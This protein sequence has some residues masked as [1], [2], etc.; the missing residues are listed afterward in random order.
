MKYAA[1]I[2]YRHAPLDMEIA[3]KVHTALET[4]KI[5]GSVRKKV[6]KSK[7][8]RVFRDQEELPIGSNLSDNISEAL[9]SSEYLI[10][11][12]SPRTPE[13]YWVQK[14]IDAFISM[15]GRDRVLAVLI[16]GEPDESFPPALLVDEKG[17]PVEPLAAD[18]RG[19]TKKERN[20]KFKTEILRL[21]APLLGCSYD[22]LKQRQKERIIKRTI[23]L[24]SAGAAVIAIAGTAF[25]IY[26][27]RVADEMTKLANE[28][29]ELADEKTK[30][31]N[32][33]LEEYKEKQENQSRFLAKEAI[34][35][36][37]SG[38]RE[39]AA[40]IAMAALPGD[41]DRPYVPEAEEALGEILHAYDLGYS[42][43]FDR[44]LPLN[45]TVSDMK[46]SPDKKHLAAVDFGS[47]VYAWD[48]ETWERTFIIKPVVLET[49][50]LDDVD[51][52]EIDDTGVY[53]LSQKLLSKYDFDGNPVY[54]KILDG[55]FKHLAVDSELDLVYC[56]GNDYICPFEASTGKELE[57][58]ETPKEN[59][60]F[61][62][63]EK[64]SKDKKYFYTV[65][66]DHDSER[67][68]LGIYKLGE[69]E[70]KEPK[71]IK[72]S[73]ESVHQ[74]FSTPAGNVALIS[75]KDNFWMEDN[76]DM[77]LDVINPETGRTLWSK[78]L[79]VQFR[80]ATTA[81]T[82]L[83]AREYTD[84]EGV[85][86]RQVVCIAESEA[87]CYDEET[88]ELISSLTLPADGCTLDLRSDNEY[89]FV[90]YTNGGIDTIN[91]VNGQIISENAIATNLGIRDVLLM[92]GR[93]IIR[94]GQSS[95]IYLLK[96]HKNK[97]LVT[98][99]EKGKGQDI[100]DVAPDGSYIV[101]SETGMLHFVDMEGNY[102]YD[103]EIGQD[104]PLDKTFYKDKYIVVGYDYL[105]I[106]SPTDKSF[107]EIK[108][109]DLGHDDKFF[110][111]RFSGK[112]RYITFWD[113][114]DYTVFDVEEKDFITNGSCESLI[115]GAVTSDDGAFVYISPNGQVL[116]RAD[117]K[118][119]S[120]DGYEC[121]DLKSLSDYNS[122]DFMALSPDGKTL[123]MLCMDGTIRIVDTESGAII[124]SHILQAKLR[125]TL[126]FT[127]DNSHLIYQGDDMKF[128]FW[129]L[130]EKKFTNTFE[131]YYGVKRLIADSDGNL[132]LCD[133]NYIFLLDDKTFA[134]KA[135]VDDAY[136]YV[137]SDKTFIQQRGYNIYKAPYK[138]Y[139]TLIE[140]AKEQFPGAKLTPEEKLKY[141]IE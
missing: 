52:I 64:F 84:S 119:D 21:I 41:D 28:K 59:W 15:H 129:N 135:I 33:I 74:V 6:N 121:A 87:F 132:A 120:V 9:S 100:C 37:E 61:F 54:A 101:T 35:V 43:E 30:L 13:S 36:M 91:F 62:S 136:T 113:S 16:E 18:V 130:N 133:G 69:E 95:D 89:G 55:Y 102:F 141:N 115:G 83:N 70:Q 81:Y 49:F 60:T 105:R 26:N 14:E 82:D 118:N 122:L 63:D 75:S 86:H 31:A 134:I 46:L 47:N 23:S 111:L 7:L 79:P 140:E 96:Y 56:I 103:F 32:D 137:P 112:G 27:A 24:V 53:V 99:C 110:K 57:I 39:D 94:A 139:K 4:Y 117:I 29:A 58:I 34:Q 107:E 104:Y 73:E 11:I 5:P 88:G 71:I 10:V 22:D 90:S 12:C 38:N 8:G 50:Y 138:D 17:N 98:I 3:K 67:E 2:S 114:R 131:G 127:D 65:L 19:E 126:F 68:F 92:D 80:R 72:L 106:V 123:A 44:T 97:D 77:W 45:L 66:N 108:F 48:T 40:L 124:D 1:F 51:A 42:M 109:A 85:I 25:G 76:P 125:C 128:Y 93:V 20:G 116:M 78:K